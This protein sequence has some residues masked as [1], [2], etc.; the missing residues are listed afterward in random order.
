[1]TDVTS[2][3]RT[4]VTDTELRRRA[5]QVIPG[6]M[7]GHLSVN[8][9]PEAYP[10][11]YERAEGCRVWDVDGN[12]YIDLMCS[13]GPIILGHKHPKV[14]RAAAV[15]RA[16][17]DTLSGPSAC[18]IELAE[19]LVDRVAHA[20][21][22]MFA[23]NGSDAN[24]L[25]LMIARAATGRNKVLAA[26]G[27]YHG[28]APWS[29]PLLK[30]VTPEDRASVQYYRFNDIE[31]LQR[32]VADAGGDVAAIIVS[33]FRHDAGFD[34]ELV[35]PAFAQALRALCD[36]I[37]AA[38]VLDEVRAGFRLNHGG[39][40]EPI[41]V[42]PDLSAWSKAIANGYPIAAVLGSQ[43]YA[44]GASSIFVTGSFWFEAVPMAASVA[45]ITA[46][47]EEDAVGSMVQRGRRLR[48]GL[49][50]QALETGLDI[51]QS[52]PVQVPNLAF[53]GDENFAR[54]RVF[55]ATAIDEGV[56]LHPRHNWFVSAALTDGDVDEVLRATEAG[57]RAVREQFGDG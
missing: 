51:S 18:M 17:G 42:K 48:E 8:T 3:Q 35:D 23:K 14:E 46:L 43:N 57:F 54:S 10:Q 9:L 4:R 32:A 19:L 11:F 34:Q 47:G 7:Y 55:C 53:V 28:S 37:G 1:M 31:S 39:S 40:W 33:P 45:T 26:R 20:D 25:C 41:G 6:G 49:A 27:A 44:A 50:A 38:L 36:R 24:T 21:W 22:A 56:I 29:T 16:K 5:R 12:E 13:F 52:G 30:G 2:K 15:Q